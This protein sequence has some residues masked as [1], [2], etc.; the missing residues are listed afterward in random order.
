MPQ[1]PSYHALF[2]ELLWDGQTFQSQYGL[3]LEGGRV[4][5]CEPHA[6]LEQRVLDLRRAGSYVTARRLPARALLPGLV[7]AHSH[8]FQRAI[9]GRTEFPVS[10]RA[11][12][13][14]KSFWGWRDCMYRAAN[15]LSPEHLEAVSRAVYI[16]M[17]TAGFTQVGEFHYL[18]HQPGGSPYPDPDELSHRVLRA[19]RGAGIGVTL[20]R[21]FY[22]RAGAGR[23]EPEEAQKL[24]CDPSAERYL[25]TL[26][27]LRAQGVPVGV[28]P[29]SVRAVGRSDLELLSAYAAQHDLP[30]HIHAA[31]QPKEIEECSSEHGLRPVEL[32]AELGALGPRTTVVH[33]IHLTPN[34]IQALGDSGARV[35]SCPST[36]RNLGDGVVPAAQLLQAGVGFCFGTDS[37]AQIHPW[38]EARQLEYHLRLVELGRSLLFESREQAGRRLL[39][40]LTDQGRRSLGLG[41]A[42][43]ALDSQA[44]L[45][46]CDL[47]HL[48]IAGWTPESLACDLVFGAERDVVTDV[49]VAGRELV[50]DRE[51]PLRRQAA[52]DLHRILR[53]LWS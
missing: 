18:H 31:E 11:E 22:R 29:H 41:P 26:D 6:D 15:R 13:P 36:E 52:E 2:P 9:R 4:A 35:C 20:L 17:L 23:P 47:D 39:D 27:R 16:E 44:D 46:A 32:L 51:H 42:A 14:G 10:G 25:E 3:L 30:F 45:I 34:E 21:T 33:A 8:A 1:K 53:D 49:W 43:P 19:G 24:F 40:A 48:S 12:D 37:Q 5:A 38:E 28:T 7:N 50:T